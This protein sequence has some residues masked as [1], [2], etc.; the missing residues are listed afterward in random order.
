MKVILR[1]SLL[2][3][4]ATGLLALAAVMPARA[5]HSNTVMTFDPGGYWRLNDTTPKTK[6]WATNSG[7]LD[8]TAAGVHYG[9]APT[10]RR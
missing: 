2:A 6:D 8:A 3:T 4:M 9:G 7:T 10:T 5:G 1:E